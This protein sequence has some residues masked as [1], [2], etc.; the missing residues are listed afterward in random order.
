[1][2]KK[3]K[4]SNGANTVML[5]LRAR[6]CQHIGDREKLEK[7]TNQLGGGGSNGHRYG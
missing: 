1:V 5:S 7:Q 6:Q 2:K 3:T 4:H